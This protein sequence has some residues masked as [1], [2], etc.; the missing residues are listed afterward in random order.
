MP[1]LCRLLEQRLFAR[2]TAVLTVSSFL[3]RRILAA[4]V[5]PARVSVVP[6]AIEP[7]LAEPVPAPES[8][9]ERYG[10]QGR[11]VVGFAGW[12][13]R[14]DRLDLLLDAVAGL[15][16]EFPALTALLVGD[17]PVADELRRQA[18][19]LDIDDRVVFTGPVPRA[20]MQEHL[21]LFDVAAL[22]HSNRFGSPVVLFEFMAR[23]LPVVAPRLDP[24]T[25]VLLDD[26]T[27]RLFKP[28][29][30]AG[31]QRALASLL[32]SEPL[33]R[34]LGDTARQRV[35]DHHTWDDNSRVILD[36]AGLALPEPVETAVRRAS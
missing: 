31:L 27:G 25:D 35:L 7:Q 4:G 19:A 15:A 22:P 32:A 28:L 1:R 3:R 8:W 12:F 13:D 10:L 17:G 23:G 2:C 34:R 16:D 24:I 33:R 29:D 6:N 9:R 21:E 5:H 36:A 20:S 14:W 26:V 18:H 30:A 11:M